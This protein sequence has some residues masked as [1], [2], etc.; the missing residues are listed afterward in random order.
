MILPNKPGSNGKYHSK[1]GRFFPLHPEKYV[2]QSTPIFK[3]DLE[4]RMMAYLDK[5]DSVVSWM[6]EPEQAIRYRDLSRPDKYG[7]GKER[8][9]YIDFVAVVKTPDNKLKTVWIE[10]KSKKETVPPKNKNNRLDMETWVRNQSKWAA[11][12]KLSESK[13]V[14]FLIITE[15]QLS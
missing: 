1:I 12:K 7:Q 9:Y 8:K 2:G 10:V 5:T 4:R 6:Y 11:A 3:S 15:D 14:Q 13:G